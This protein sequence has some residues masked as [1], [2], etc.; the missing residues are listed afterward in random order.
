MPRKKQIV[1]TKKPKGLTV[2]TTQILSPE[3]MAK[4]HIP[5]DVGPPDGPTVLTGDQFDALWV[6]LSPRGKEK[7]RDYADRLG[8]TNRGV[9]NRFPQFRVG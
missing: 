3:R 5:L 1:G 7:V 9:L 6:K 8:L 2:T 4:A